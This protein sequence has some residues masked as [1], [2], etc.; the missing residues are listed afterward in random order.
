MSIFYG[1]RFSQFVIFGS[2]QTF[3]NPDNLYFDFL[4]HLLLVK[5]NIE[6][7]PPCT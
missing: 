2:N 7:V 3:Q 1:T 4:G 6:F 5:V